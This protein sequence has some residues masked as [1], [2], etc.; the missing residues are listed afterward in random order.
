MFISYS[1]KRALP[2]LP[3]GIIAANTLLVPVGQADE[4]MEIIAVNGTRYQDDSVLALSHTGQSLTVISRDMIVSAGAV[5]INEILN[6]FVPGLFANGRNGRHTDTDYSLQGS[7]PVDILW[8]L[9]GNRLNNRLYG[10]TYTDSIN[11]MMIERIEVIKG[12]QGLIYGS[13]A[14]AGVVNIITRDSHGEQGGEVNLSADTLTSYDLGAYVSGGSD[15]LSYSLSGSSSQS[16]GYA[17]WEDDEYSPVAA[18]DKDRGYRMM[19]IGG[20]LNWQPSAQHKITLFGQYNNGVLERPLAYSAIVS[21][22][23][24]KQTLAWL[25]WQ[26]QATDKLSLETRLHYQNWDSYYS[27]ITLEP[28]GSMT[29]PYRDA[30]WGFTD[31]GAKVSGRYQ[32]DSGDSWLGGI[33]WQSYYGADEVMELQAPT[34]DTKAAFLQYKPHFSALPG[35]VL[36]LGLRYNR[37]ANNEDKWVASLGLEQELGQNWQLK[38]AVGNGFRQPTSSE[39]WAKVGT[40]GNPEL[41]SEE[42]INTNLTLVYQGNFTFSVE[43]YWRETDN[44][45]DK[46]EI[47]TNVWQYANLDGKVRGQGVDIQYIMNP[48]QGWQ[49]ELSGSYNRARERGKDQQIERIPQ[50]MGFARLSWD[51]TDSLNL[52]LQGRYVGEFTDYGLK[53][54]DYL[55]TGI[56]ADWWLTASQNQQLTL[57]ID[58]LFDEDNTSAIFK[59]GHKAEYPIPT[60]GAPRTAQLIYRYL[61]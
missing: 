47:A 14:I 12:A 38:A 13:D 60:L 9:D 10:S 52:Y 48:A 55:L 41:E 51:A 26:Y 39:L 32:A 43:A 54:S 44:L 28:D 23:E 11:P 8:L 30:Y 20:K 31:K 29:I 34:D 2:W 4:A 40:L 46:R 17:F 49:L 15:T 61:F 3:F 25:G 22:N 21:E 36:A 59:H 56:G 45:V 24:R 42:S 33:E 58:N 16:D 57:R 1:F 6:Q 27:E 19:N 18:E 5:D 35:T 37:L 53:A 7:R 50:Y